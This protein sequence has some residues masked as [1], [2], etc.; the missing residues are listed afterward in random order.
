[1]EGTVR[2]LTIVE[3]DDQ[4]GGVGSA[5]QVK[6]KEYIEDPPPTTH[7][8]SMGAGIYIAICIYMAICIH[9]GICIYIAISFVSQLS[10]V[11]MVL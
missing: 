5:V 7:P 10:N 2:D 11:L 6:V 3:A 8:I 4:N 9:I 1:V